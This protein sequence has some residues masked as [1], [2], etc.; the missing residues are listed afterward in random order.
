LS[1]AAGAAAAGRA[2]QIPATQ[3][4]DEHSSGE[5]HTPPSGTKVAVAVAVAVTVGVT[6]GDAV[7]VGVAVAVAVGVS[8]KVAVAVGVSVKVAV[9]VAVAVGVA[10]AVA[11]AVYGTQKA[12]TVSTCEV[13]AVIPRHEASPTKV[14]FSIATQLSSV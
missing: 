5:I 11:V 3:R 10:V 13:V 6:V 4:P 9:A 8:V 14:P 7:T 2:A 12:L 1:D